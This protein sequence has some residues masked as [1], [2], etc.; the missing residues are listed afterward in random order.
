MGARTNAERRRLAGRAAALW[1]GVVLGSTATLGA[2]VVW[3][4]VR[5]GRL[6]RDRQPPPRDVRLPE[7]DEVD[8][9]APGPLPAP[10]ADR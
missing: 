9:D 2:L 7:W 1:G 5:R 4:L 10:R 6:I 8:P 3:H